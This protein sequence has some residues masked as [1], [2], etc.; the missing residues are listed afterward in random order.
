M[1]DDSSLL[2]HSAARP[3]RATDALARVAAVS[4]SEGLPTLADRLE[5]VRG[6]LGSDLDALEGE[7][8]EL[9]NNT[10]APNL[11]Q[12]AA[13]HL[14]RQKGKRLRPV[15]THLGA[16]LSGLASDARVHQL[17][18][19]SE[20]VHAATLLHDDVI[21]EGNE[22]RGAPTARVVYGNS[23]SILAGDYLLTEALRR[24]ST[25]G[26]TALTTLL[27][28]IGQMVAAEA[29][30]LEQR[31]QFI[32]DR[33]VYYA[34]I[35]GKTASLF[36][37]ALSAAAQL[38]SPGEAGGALVEPLGRMG[39][40]L[41]IAFQLVDDALDLEGAP[42]EIGKDLFADLAQGKLTF[43]LIAACEAEPAVARTIRAFAADSAAG[44]L[45]ADQAALLVARLRAA[46]ALERTRDLADHHK[47]RALE[48]LA[49]LPATRA[50]DALGA[51]ITAAVER[52]S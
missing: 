13:R 38:A 28:T 3:R 30:Q 31:G 29:L 5:Q 4:R 25:T 39:I 9:E 24:V 12:R 26:G 48:A 37:W 42:E 45:E 49:D 27:D 20:L 47:R 23:A 50:A 32:P 8:A 35:E 51:V 41:G 7:I 36:R 17:A 52:R 44:I 10:A 16:R 33:D 11:A 14:L 1:T 43:P 22:R 34:I 6:F 19:A 2:L 40:E 21:D 46:G 18:V 15:C